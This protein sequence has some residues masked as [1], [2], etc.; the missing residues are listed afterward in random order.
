LR[1]EDPGVV[2][3]DEFVGQWLTLAIVEL[4]LRVFP[5]SLGAPSLPAFLLV[6]FLLFRLCDIGKPWPAGWADRELHGGFGTMLD[7]AFAGIWAGVLAVA[8][9]WVLG[10]FGGG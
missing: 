9:L 4:A 7:D 5:N 8:A 3:V 1:I 10:R 6:G 2:V